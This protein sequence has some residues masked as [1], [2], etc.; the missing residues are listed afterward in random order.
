MLVVVGIF[1]YTVCVTDACADGRDI[2]SACVDEDVGCADG[3]GHVVSNSSVGNGDAVVLLVVKVKI[4]TVV[5]W[6][7]WY[8]M[9]AAM[10]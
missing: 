5:C 10:V 9:A 6:W 3:D 8:V 7:P 2:P 4:G 1:D